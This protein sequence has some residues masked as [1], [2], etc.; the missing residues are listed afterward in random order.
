MLLSSW[1]FWV[2]LV[3]KMRHLWSPHCGRI[4]RRNLDKC[5]D[6]MPIGTPCN[7]FDPN[8]A[9]HVQCLVN[10]VYHVALPIDYILLIECFWNTVSPFIWASDFRCST[11]LALYSSHFLALAKLFLQFE[12]RNIY[13]ICTKKSHLLHKWSIRM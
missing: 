11:E 10:T 1:Y 12:F 2:C 8:H 7:L 3:Q 13:W 4:L 6:L 9:A 5:F